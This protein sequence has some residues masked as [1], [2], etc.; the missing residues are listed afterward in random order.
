MESL[1]IL[2]LI[3]PLLAIGLAIYTKDVIISLVIS[4]LL[5]ATMACG[6]NVYQSGITIL[7]D[8]IFPSVSDS[9]NAQS[10][11]M[12][13]VV[14]GFTEL[15]TRS[16]GGLAFTNVVTQGLSAKQPCGSAVFSSG[17]QTWATP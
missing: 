17:S 3:P 4:V 14:G 15:I 9:T 13:I 2:S 5:A 6:G 7:Q 8:W 12:L 16:G 11:L 10:I 1:G